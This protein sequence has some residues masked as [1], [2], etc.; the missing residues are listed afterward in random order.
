MTFSDELWLVIIDKAILAI[1]VLVVGYWINRRLEKDKANEMIR[2]KIAE[3]RAKTYLSLWQL[4]AEIDTLG[5]EPVSPE[6]VTHLLDKVTDWYYQQGN[7]LYLSHP[8]TS[9]FLEGRN[10]LKNPALEAVALKSVFSRL[11]TQMK[12]D[13]GVY[14]DNEARL[15]VK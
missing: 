15:P 13:I 2:Q 5:R 1:G 3:S 6:K 11:R 10:M 12:Q 4:T 14:T 7:G 9:L 8:A